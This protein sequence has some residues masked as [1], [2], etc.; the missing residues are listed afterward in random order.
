MPANTYQQSRQKYKC[1]RRY[2][3]LLLAIVVPV[4]L[5]VRRLGLALF[6]SLVPR[7]V[8]MGLWCAVIFGIV[9]YLEDWPCPRCGKVF[10]RKRWYGLGT[11][12]PCCVHCGLPKYSNG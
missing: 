6:G 4:D 8:I 11:L 2:F 10:S 1:L 5:L 3:F 12:P 9:I 7:I